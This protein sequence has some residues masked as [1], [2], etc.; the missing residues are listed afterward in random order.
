[1]NHPQGR[2]TKPA[3]GRQTPTRGAP[4][5]TS[6]GKAL[7]APPEPPAAHRPSRRRRWRGTLTLIAAAGLTLVLIDRRPEWREPVVPP[8]V[9]KAVVKSWKEAVRRVEEDRH[10]R[11]G[12]RVVVPMPPELLH[13]D[14]RRRFLAVQVAETLEREYVL[15][16]DEYDL[17]TLAR[18]GELVEMS[19]V[20]ETYVLYGVGALATGEPLCRYDRESG[21]D[22]PLY[23][24]Y[25]AYLQADETSDAA[26]S[27]L[28]DRQARLVAE[29]ARLGR[30]AAARRRA[31]TAEIAALDHDRDVIIRRQ[32]RAAALYED[33]ETRR[34]LSGKLR[35]LEAT[36]RHLDPSYDLDE[37][38]GRRALRGRLASLIR[39]QARDVLLEI[40]A[41]YHQLFRRPLPIT[42][43]VRSQRYQER[44]RLLNPNATNIEAPPHATGLAFDVYTGHMSGTEQ[45]YL[46]AA[47][48]RLEQDGRVEALFERNRQHVHVFVFADGARPP[49][50][51]IADSLA[52]V[53]PP[54]LPRRRVPGKA[55]PPVAAAPAAAKAPLPALRALR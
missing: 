8:E 4:P 44:L 1:M 3:G 25:L 37:P 31:L 15:P 42:S 49:E 32:E 51:L 30:K 55:K 34:L 45:S 22:I 20:G 2:P 17:A 24:D 16:A 21:L 6:L 38:A 52:R 23:P 5:F 11:V 14:D 36:A 19:Q 41:G 48:S 26:V 39:P 53:G 54:V 35:F 27:K 29:R 40:A 13:Y 46:F 7:A 47:V 18:T 12:S 33:F 28:H 9:P 50:T 10:E 43:L